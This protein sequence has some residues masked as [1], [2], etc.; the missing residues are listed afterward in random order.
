MNLRGADRRPC[1]PGCRRTMT[2][3]VEGRVPGPRAYGPRAS[4]PMRRAKTGREGVSKEEVR[5]EEAERAF[6]AAPRGRD[7][8]DRRSRRVGGAQPLRGGAGAKVGA[9]VHC[10]TVLLRFR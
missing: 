8:G 3:I 2:E 7:T 5:R 6:Q 1:P 10:A 9:V 4:T